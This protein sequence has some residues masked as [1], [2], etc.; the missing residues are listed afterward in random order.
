MKPR[1]GMIAKCAF[2]EEIASS[3]LA[4]GGIPVLIPIQASPQLAPDYISM[5]EGLLVPGGEDVTPF[6]YGQDPCAK[7]TIS[8]QDKDQFEI[9]LIKEAIK[10]NKPIFGICRGQ[11]IINVALGGTLIQDIPSCLPDAVCHKQDGVAKTEPIHRVYLE[12][13]EYLEVL[14]G[15]REIDA[16]SLH[17]QSIDRLADGLK[18]AARTADGIIEGIESE[19]GR[20]FGVQWHPELLYTQ[21]PHF[22]KLFS[23][24]I[25]LAG[26]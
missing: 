2:P 23:R 26:Q 14:F 24:L 13:D 5:V 19:D 9:A 20:I 21:Y 10:Q 17:H 12:K 25:E 8:Y 15:H 11:Q 18:V 16:N 22:L 4:A 7:V 1:I 6:L 3:I